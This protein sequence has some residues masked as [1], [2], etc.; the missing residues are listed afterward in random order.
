MVAIGVT[1]FVV[2]QQAVGAIQVV[3]GAQAIEN[4]YGGEDTAAGL[5]TVG[6]L[7]IGD[8]AADTQ[9]VTTGH[10]LEHGGSEGASANSSTGFHQVGEIDVVEGV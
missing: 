3:V 5:Q 1:K 10:I 4:A 6:H 9:G 2:H 8:Q 7:A